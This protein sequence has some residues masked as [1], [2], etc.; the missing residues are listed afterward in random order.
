MSAGTGADATSHSKVLAEP[1]ERE[2]PLPLLFAGIDLGRWLHVVS[3][4]DA[5]GEFV[6]EQGFAHS[7]EGLATVIDWLIDLAEQEPKRLRIAIEKPHGAV[8]DMFLMRDIAVFAVNPKQV[9]RFRDRFAL[10]GAKDDRRDAFVLADALRTDGHRFQR[11]SLPP[12]DIIVLREHLRSRSQLVKQHVAL[13]SQ[14][15]ELI[16]G[17]WPHLLELAPKNKAIDAFFGE[18]LLLFFDLD[19]SSFDSLPAL[20]KKHHIRRVSAEEVARTLQAPPLYTAPGTRDAAEAHVT[21][22][23]NQLLLVVRLRRQADQFL[24]RW[25]TKHQKT[26]Y[27]NKLTDA[28]I[29]ASLPGVGALVLA[30]LLCFAH[31]AIRLRNLDAL[32]SLGGV[33]PVTKQSGKRRQVLLRRAR[34]QPLNFALHHW[35]H[36]A[37]LR[38]PKSE[39]HYR[40]L[41]NKGHSHARA[42]RGV[43][44]RML[45]VALAMLRDRVLYDPTKRK[46]LSS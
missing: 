46:E 37:V 28:A 33:A 4:V 10:S 34:S 15:R 42:L 31:D 21:L 25:F 44:D 41:R 17:C 39:Q 29:L 19:N 12:P 7:V 2:Q 26:S 36:M 32:R 14:L 35:A 30:S 8:V 18:L 43:I 5:N 23:V 24:E 22:L 6:V 27:N 40:R 16:V 13:S 1:R 11:L 38:D 20:I 3:V 45:S 9:D